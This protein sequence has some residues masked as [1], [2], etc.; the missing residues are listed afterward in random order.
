ML[1]MKKIISL[2]MAFALMAS[3]M[4]VPAAAQNDMESVL[5][6]VLEAHR[7]TSTDEQETALEAEESAYQTLYALPYTNSV[8]YDA[9][10]PLLTDH[11]KNKQTFQ[12]TIELEYLRD[13]TVTVTG[14]NAATAARLD[15]FLSNNAAIGT[16]Y[17]LEGATAAQAASKYAALDAAL[18]AV[19]DD[20][21][22]LKQAVSTAGATLLVDGA[23]YTGLTTTEDIMRE[24]ITGLLKDILAVLFSTQGTWEDAVDDLFS[25]ANK[26]LIGS[27]FGADFSATISTSSSVAAISNYIKSN[28]V[29]TSM[30]SRQTDLFTGSLS[31][32]NTAFYAMAAEIFAGLFE[33]SSMANAKTGFLGS[34]WTSLKLFNALKSVAD[35]ADPDFHSGI[36]NLNMIYGRYFEIH[37]ND[38]KQSYPLVL[39]NANLSSAS[40]NIKIVKG[41]YSAPIVNVLSAVA[42]EGGLVSTRLEANCTRGALTFNALSED[43]QG[44]YDLT[45]YRSGGPENVYGYIKTATA[46]VDDDIPVES[47]TIREGRTVTLYERDTKQL[48]LQILPAN[49][50]NKAVTW[51]N[52]DPSVATISASGLI[53][54]LSRGTTTITVTTADGAYTAVITV[55]VL[56]R[57]SSS[58]TTGPGG[59]II[60]PGGETS[61]LWDIEKHW[62]ET[63]IRKLVER[64]II[65][66]YG[67]GTIRPDLDISRAEFAKIAVTLMELPMV[68]NGILFE[69]TENH[70]SRDYVATAAKYGVMIGYTETIFAP[71]QKIPREQVIAV[72]LRIVNFDGDIIN[73]GDVVEVYGDAVIEK[74]AA[75]Y[76]DPNAIYAETGFTD[77]D[78]ATPW[79]VPYIKAAYTLGWLKGYE[80]GTIRPRVNS[81][82]AEAM[83]IA[84][85]AMFGD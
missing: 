50:T 61:S 47:V 78:D 6:T 8:W 37:K 76:M 52:S 44:D 64:G 10:D 32:A 12:R 26:K 83:V 58:T 74:I 82:R 9:V 40:F 69:D 17:N 38:V 63:E 79:T 34:G 13:R 67:D 62:A 23:P 41:A 43:A 15:T 49:A 46:T 75:E 70:W 14:G 48:T 71:D 55:T 22:R 66:G 59:V 5:R 39:H 80:D 3:I 28:T 16:D 25:D 29:L 1:K 18:T 24:K 73:D 85:R 77:I 60:G 36:I 33:L 7:A 35:A 11:I 45:F 53:T 72:V 84:V 21:V 4:A 27:M 56:R 31:E 30:V 57:G 42:Y 51:T 54:A 81:T 20:L 2:V 68:E 19:Y 65:D